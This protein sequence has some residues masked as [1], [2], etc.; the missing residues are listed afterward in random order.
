[1]GLRQ[2]LVRLGGFGLLLTLALSVSAGEV[3]LK[4]WIDGPVRY[5][6]RKYEVQEFKKLKTDDARVLFIEKFWHLR[7]PSPSTLSN[8]YRHLFWERVAEANSQFTDSSKPGWMTDRGKIH[9]LYGPPTDRQ[10]DLHLRTDESITG[11]GYGIIRWI[12]EGRPGERGD[13]DAITVVPFVRDGSGE[14]RITYDPN[15]SSVF[16]DANAIRDA[17]YDLGQSLRASTMGGDRSRLSVM[18]DL[19]KMQEVPPESQVLMERVETVEAYRT[20]PVA[21]RVDRYLREDGLTEVVITAGLGP[22]GPHPKPAV[23]ARLV[24][25][26]GS[27]PQRM[28]GEDSFRVVETD[29]E[30]FAQGRLAVEPGVYM[31]TLMVAD[32][33]LIKTS[34]Y[35]NRLSV[36]P[37]TETFRFSDVGWAKELVPLEFEALA[38]YDEPFIVG[39]YNVLPKID[40]VFRRGQVLKLFYEVYGGAAPFRVSYQ[41]QGKENDGSWTSLGQPSLSDQPNFAQAWELP[42]NPRWPLG[43]YRVEIEV[44]DADG[45]QI[46]RHVTFELE[47]GAGSSTRT[48]A[49]A[50]AAPGDS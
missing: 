24:D 38:G 39:P 40:S 20:S 50:E 49:T 42:T 32:P 8:A 22:A 27:G 4:K 48:Q 35:Q 36:H 2:H 17:K 28:L 41:L 34:L 3:Q 6:A 44:V 26:A 19:G 33:V 11:G 31:L 37:P 15:L 47:A 1:M 18:L 13:L 23:I 12:Y 25:D 45:K 14:Y 46:A 7:D 16:F 10:E 29:G 21:T 30:R 5:I 9:I 43:E